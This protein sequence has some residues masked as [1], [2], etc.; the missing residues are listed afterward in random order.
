MFI[1]SRRL[2]L[3]FNRRPAVVLL[4]VLIVVVLLSLAAYQYSELMMAQ[5]RATDSYS[6]SSQATALA[7][8][9]VHYV[10]ATLSDP[11]TFTN[12]LNSN[13]WDNPT[14]FQDILVSDN[15]NTKRRGHFSILTVRDPDDPALTPDNV[16]RY[17]VGDEAGKLNLNYLL[18]LAP[19]D[20]VRLQMLLMIPNMT[21]DVANS[22]LDWLDNSSTIP[23]TNGAKDDYYPSLTPPYHVKNG[24]LDSLEE[25]LLVKGVTPQ[26][27]YGNDVNRNGIID[28]D[29]DP[30]D[31]T[32]DQGWQQY[33]TIYSREPNLD[34]TGNPRI[35]LNNTDL[36]GLNTSLQT[37]V[38]PDLTQFILAYRLYGPAAAPMGGAAG[39]AAATPKFQR[40]SGAAASTV[41]SAIS[42]S[43]SQGQQRRLTSISSLFSLATAQVQMPAQGMQPAQTIPNPLSDPGQA[44]TLLPQLF[45]KT[46]TKK[47][48]DLTPRINVNTASRVVLSMLPGLQDTDVQAILDNRPPMVSNQAPDPMYLTPA[49][50]LTSGVLPAKTLSGLESYITTRSQVYR[51][52]VQGYFEGPGPVVRVEAVVDVNNGRPRVVMY[53][54]MTDLGKGFTPQKLNGTQ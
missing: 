1:P 45:D 19:T 21:E 51:F 26:L 41:S 17:G 9:G 46:T 33:F 24:P 28:P 20:T 10:A 15:D 7:K 30:G 31:G 22:I 42:T 40:L 3:R 6:R 11:D 53:R 12:T 13:P 44:G 50:L 5:Y 36:N 54:P 34:S 14:A 25:L 16:T 39:G 52:Q 47:N 35:Y 37:A 49:W 38:G 4:S 48:A 27:L 23:R 29:E 43:L 18:T 2:R 8:S 32:V